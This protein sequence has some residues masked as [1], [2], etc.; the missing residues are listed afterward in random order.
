MKITCKKIVIA[1]V[2]LAVLFDLSFFYLL[3]ISTKI[4]TYRGFFVDA[5]GIISALIACTCCKKSL[6]G[7]VRFINRYAKVFTF[8]MLATAVYSIIAYPSQSFFQMLISMRYYLYFYL[9]YGLLVTLDA[10]GIDGFMRRLNLTAVIWYVLMILQSA[11]YSQTGRLILNYF[12]EDNVNVRVGIRI[13]M[14]VAG[15]VTM[16]YNYCVVLGYFKSSIK[17]PI[18]LVS[19][20]LGLYALIIVEQTRAHII[21][22]LGAMLIMLLVGGGR[23]RMIFKRLC[24]LAAA[25]AVI[26]ASGYMTSMIGSIFGTAETEIYGHYGQ[27]RR[28][29]E[30]AY[31]WRCFLENPFCGIGFATYGNAYDTV[32]RGPALEFF[33][34]DVGFVGIVGQIGIF[35]FIL[36]G[37]LIAR[38]TKIVINMKKCGYEYSPLFVG[39]YAYILLTSVSLIMFWSTTA[40][41]FPL[42]LA[43]FE[44]GYY[45]SRI[46]Y[47]N[48]RRNL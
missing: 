38:F 7:K 36:Y 32:V 48:R 11:V 41:L 14:F 28:F 19:L 31:Y 43:M 20:G 37:W 18:A 8:A 45:H 34:N 17:K 10:Y 3:K 15:H 2:F 39:L 47:Y 27:V 30:M 24:I 33:M 26:V 5:A 16:L 21:A 44:Y 4:Q 13:A 29:D 9:A 23:K 35:A 25:Y 46:T 22:T 1:L 12:S 6:S 40:L 42:S